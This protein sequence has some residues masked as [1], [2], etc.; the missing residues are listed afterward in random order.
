MP[1]AKRALAE[2]TNLEHR[3]GGAAEVLEGADLFIGLSGRACSPA[4]RCGA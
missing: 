3:S 4:A 2:L 1:A